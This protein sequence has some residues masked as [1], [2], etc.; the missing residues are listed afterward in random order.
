[1]ASAHASTGAR[2]ETWWGSTTCSC[3]RPQ[4]LTFPG[5]LIEAWGKSDHQCPL[6]P[7]KQTNARKIPKTIQTL[8]QR[9]PLTSETVL[10]IAHKGERIVLIIIREQIDLVPLRSWMRI[11]LCLRG[12]NFAKGKAAPEN[13]NCCCDK[14]LSGSSLA[15]SNR[16][17]S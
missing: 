4:R 1:M 6:R 8:N 9:R 3:M 16:R 13:L 15:R 11:T 2:A 7:R 17:A 10:A 12:S 5:S 14:S